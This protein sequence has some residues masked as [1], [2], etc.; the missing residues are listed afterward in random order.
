MYS[1]FDVC[2]TKIDKRQ[3]IGWMALPLDGEVGQRASACRHAAK[4]VPPCTS[5]ETTLI[6][7][8]LCRER[9]QEATLESST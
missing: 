2:Q 6:Y 5:L 9:R 8:Y 7:A 4:R 3:R 1:N